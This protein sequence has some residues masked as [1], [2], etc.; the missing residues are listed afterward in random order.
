MLGMYLTTAVNFLAADTLEWQHFLGHFL[1]RHFF[2]KSN[3]R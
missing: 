2:S 3:W 1:Y